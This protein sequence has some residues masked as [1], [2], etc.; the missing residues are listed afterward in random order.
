MT[1]WSLDD[2]HVSLLDEYMSFRGVPHIIEFSL[3]ENFI[4][5]VGAAIIAAS[6][7]NWVRNFSLFWTILFLVLNDL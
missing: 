2:Y 4:S 7:A 6:I 5:H 1:R 3:G